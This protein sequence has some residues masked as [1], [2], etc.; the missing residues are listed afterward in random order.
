MLEDNP[1]ELEEIVTVTQACGLDTLATRSPQQAIRLLRANDPVL[2]IL[3]WNMRLSP[4]AE[5]TAENV[6]RTLARDHEGWRAR[7]RGG[8]SVSADV[9]AAKDLPPPRRGGAPCRCN[10]WV[11]MRVAAALGGQSDRVLQ[12]RRATA[13]ACNVA[14]TRDVW[15]Q[16]L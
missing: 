1:T 11:A 2:A 8:E 6:L 5:R 12:P 10:D 16:K 4:D 15:S 9:T 14:M 3:D 13:A 7:G